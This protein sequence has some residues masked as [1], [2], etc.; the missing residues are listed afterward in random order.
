MGI[1]YKK[2]SLPLCNIGKRLKKKAGLYNTFLDLPS[3]ENTKTKLSNKTE[4]IQCT[5]MNKMQI[6]EDNAC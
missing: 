3:I 4:W 2:W 6:L 1:P 5:L